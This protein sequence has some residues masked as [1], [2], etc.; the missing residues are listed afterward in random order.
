M[1]KHPINTAKRLRLTDKCSSGGLLPKQIKFI[2]EYLMCKRHA[3]VL[4]GAQD[5]AK[6]RTSLG[7][8]LKKVAPRRWLKSREKLTT[9]QRVRPRHEPTNARS[10]EKSPESAS[11]RAECS[12]RPGIPYPLP[13]LTMI[14]GCLHRW[15]CWSREGAG[16]DRRPCRPAKEIQDCRDKNAALDKAAKIH[17]HVKRT[18]PRTS[19]SP[20]CIVP[21]KGRGLMKLN[22]AGRSW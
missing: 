1:V 17:W 4:P 7:K 6:Q 18:T 3:R 8:K 19:P 2:D 14:M 11:M 9:P 21:A 13:S 5:T 10:S 12:P 20:G 22:P 16:D 15:E